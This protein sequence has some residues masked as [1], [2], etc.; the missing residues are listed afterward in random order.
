MKHALLIFTAVLVCRA[1]E[2]PKKVAITF[3][4]LPYASGVA[5]GSA[6][7]SDGA[8]ASALTRKLLKELVKRGVPVTGFVIQHR[9]E[10][11][12]SAGPAILREWLKAGFDLANHT[13]SHADIN[14]LAV[15]QIEDQIVRG[16]AAI[17]PLMRQA[18][19]KLEF[20]RF[21]MNHTGDTAPKRDAIAEFLRARGYRVAACT[22]DTSDYVFNAAYV[23]LLTKRMASRAAD[24]RREYLTYSGA[25]IDYYAALNRRVLGYEPPEIMLLHAN[26]LNSDSMR[27]ILDL[28]QQ[29]GYSFIPLGEALADPVY[30]K[31][32]VY[33]TKFGPMWGYRWAAERGVKVNG[34][35]EPDPPQW[36]SK[37]ASQ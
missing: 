21:P 36:I 37:L 9:V 16:E 27:E 17:A 11:L 13:Y 10:E 22:I 24:V 14:Q 32:P 1:A 20:F 12:G 30:L 19:R 26:R 35:L 31:P 3:D 28:F 29:R 8:L 18:G 6:N 7:P 33:V 25:E 34:A 5:T 23:R 15:E 2:S 4:D